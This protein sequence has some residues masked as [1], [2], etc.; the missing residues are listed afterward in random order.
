MARFQSRD[1]RAQLS[2]SSGSNN[3]KIEK[4]IS[5]GRIDTKSVPWG[6]SSMKAIPDSVSPMTLCGE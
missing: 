3:A 1:T 2:R 5:V 6:T 4:E